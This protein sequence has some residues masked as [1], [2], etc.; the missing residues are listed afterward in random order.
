MRLKSTS[1]MECNLIYLCTKTQ[2]AKTNLSPFQSMIDGH[3]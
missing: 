3:M 2:Q 1:Y